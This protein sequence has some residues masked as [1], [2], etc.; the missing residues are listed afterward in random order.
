MSNIVQLPHLGCEIA[1]ELKV[2]IRCKVKFRDGDGP[3]YYFARTRY[4][5][6][7]HEVTARDC[8]RGGLYKL[9]ENGEYKGR[10]FLQKNIDGDNDGDGDDERVQV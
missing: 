5:Q 6:Y 4:R 1:K 2:C 7:L 9:T 8:Y 3:C 10:A